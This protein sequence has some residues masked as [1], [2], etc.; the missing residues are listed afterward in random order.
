M[1]NYYFTSDLHF[2]HD[3]SFLFK[4]RGFNSTEEMCETIVQKWNNKIKADDVVFIL[5]DLILTDN[6]KGKYYLSYLN[7]I[8]FFVRGNHDSKNRLEIYHDVGINDLG[9]AHTFQYKPQNVK[10]KYNFYLS[11]FP[12]FTGNEFE[13]HISQQYINLFGHTHQKDNFFQDNYFMYHVGLDSHNCEPVH[14]DDI[15]YDV[16]KKYAE[17]NFKI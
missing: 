5:G 17:N 14:I 13:P 16:G 7:G 10:W 15:L 6:E 8:K 11:H 3:K 9:W 1:T 2:A 12:T 4:P